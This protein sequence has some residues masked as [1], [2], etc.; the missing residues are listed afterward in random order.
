MPPGAVV[1]M[2]VAKA[3]A[4]NNTGCSCGCVL[5]YDSGVAVVMTDHNEWRWR[6]WH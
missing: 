5:Q 4:A 1:A 3:E 6:G 2:A